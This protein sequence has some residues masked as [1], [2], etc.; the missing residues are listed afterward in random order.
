MFLRRV[1][2]IRCPVMAFCEVV[3]EAIRACRVSANIVVA[4]DVQRHRDGRESLPSPL[5]LGP[6]I[7]AVTRQP[8]ALR[9]ARRNCHRS[10]SGRTLSEHLFMERA[11]IVWS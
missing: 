9:S 4:Q 8:L 1:A 3:C 2:R 6:R 10:L 7:M 11:I 5:R